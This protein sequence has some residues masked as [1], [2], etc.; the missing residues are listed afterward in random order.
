MC[1]MNSKMKY[2][3]RGLCAESEHDRV[4]FLEKAKK[5]RMP[6]FKGLSSSIITYNEDRKTWILK[7]LR[8]KLE[9]Y[10]AENSVDTV[11]IGRKVWILNDPS[12]TRNQSKL[13][14]TKCE[15][16]QFTCNDGSC[17]QDLGLRCDLKPDCPDQSDELNCRRVV[18]DGE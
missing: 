3:L 5:G 16:G 14:L 4:F 7:H 13:T 9:G 18:I 15:E 17:L 2:S 10:L 8:Y 1:Q 11:P 12:C 6:Y